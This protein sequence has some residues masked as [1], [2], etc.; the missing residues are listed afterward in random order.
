MFVKAKEYRIGEE[1]IEE[2]KVKVPMD[3]TD[4][5][6]WKA[7]GLLGTA[8][9][10][11]QGVVGSYKEHHL[12]NPYGPSLEKPEGHQPGVDSTSHLN[13]F[14]KEHSIVLNKK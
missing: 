14:V 5:R 3:E 12:P 6:L 8:F 1:G 2:R 7:M 9:I 10:V 11:G 4:A 13:K